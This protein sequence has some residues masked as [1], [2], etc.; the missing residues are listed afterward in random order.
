MSSWSGMFCLSNLSQ[1][2]MIVWIMDFIFVPDHFKKKRSYFLFLRDS[3]LWYWTWNSWTQGNCHASSQS[4][5]L[6]WE[7]CLLLYCFENHYN[8]SLQPQPFKCLFH[9]YIADTHVVEQVK[10]LCE[11]NSKTGNK[12]NSPDL[13]SLF[14][15]QS[16]SQVLYNLEVSAFLHKITWKSLKVWS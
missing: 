2:S 13:E 5:S 3:W 9:C 11:E 16:P 14:F 4:N 12:T 6:R 10:N 8:I 7:S 1:D 15:S